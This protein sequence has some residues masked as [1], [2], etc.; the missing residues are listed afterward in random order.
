M[1]DFPKAAF[2]RLLGFFDTSTDDVVRLT[3]AFGLVTKIHMGQLNNKSEQYIN[4]PLRVALILVDELQMRDVELACAALLHDT[5]DNI[6]DEELKE[7]GERTYAAVRGCNAIGSS[8]QLAALPKATKDVRYVLLAERL[9]TARSM[10]NRAL[11]DKRM[12]FREETEKYIVPV[13][14]ATDDRLA[15]KLSVALYELK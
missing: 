6:K 3:R 11:L 8:D 12:R 10:K 15:F 7:F 4:H 5:S 2:A 9:D 13:A 1:S 14:I